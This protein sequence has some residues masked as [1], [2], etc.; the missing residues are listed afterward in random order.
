[1]TLAEFK[2]A[3]LAGAAGLMPPDDLTIS[4]LRAYSLGCEAWKEAQIQE[5]GRLKAQARIA[6]GGA[7]S[8][9]AALIVKAIVESG[10]LKK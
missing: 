8:P 7:V 6:R 9:E 4:E 5:E 3:W 2:E 10:G 1:M